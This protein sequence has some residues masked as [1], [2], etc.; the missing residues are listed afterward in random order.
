MKIQACWYID[1]DSVDLWKSLPLFE[2]T[3]TYP[4]FKMAIM[5]LYPGVDDDHKWVISDL[6]KLVGAWSRNGIADSNQLGTY[7][8]SFLNILHFLISKGCLSENEQSRVYLWGFSMEFYNS[9][10]HRLQVKFPDNLA[11]HPFSLD[12]IHEAAE[13]VLKSASGTYLSSSIFPVPAAITLQPCPASQESL[14]MSFMTKEDLTMALGQF[15]QTLMQALWP[16]PLSNRPRSKHKNCNFCGSLE[17][18]IHDCDVA[19]QYIK[20][21]KCRRNIDGKLILPSESFIPKIIPGQWFKDHFDEYHKWNPGQ[22]AVEQLSVV[23]EV[24]QMIYECATNSSEILPGSPIA[25]QVLT[26]LVED[27]IQILKRE[28]F[29]LY[30]K[31][32]IFDGVEVP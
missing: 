5:K 27:Y 12:Q 32:Q 16:D 2:E 20:E 11:N 25:I 28:L 13:F 15:T 1:T 9:I 14:V 6:D 19:E 17:H 26:L 24:S 8:H 23:A 18:W 10:M 7:Y 30:V 3:S 29:A 22:L 21:G 31:K 4:A